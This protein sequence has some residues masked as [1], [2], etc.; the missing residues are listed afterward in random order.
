MSHAWTLDEVCDHAERA[1]EY[2]SE[3]DPANA[4]REAVTSILSDLNKFDLGR[5]VLREID[6]A[7]MLRIMTESDDTSYQQLVRL[8]RKIHVRESR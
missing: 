5:R 6:K 2:Y 1:F 8:L 4:V 7:E 3:R